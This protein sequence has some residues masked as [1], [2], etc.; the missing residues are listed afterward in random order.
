[1]LFPDEASLNL[2]CRSKMEHVSQKVGERFYEIG[3][4]LG[5]TEFAEFIRK[6][7]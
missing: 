7:M 4:P 1:M 6:G 3:S 5:L 2:A